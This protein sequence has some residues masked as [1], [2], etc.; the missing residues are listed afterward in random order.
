MFKLE[1]ALKWLAKFQCKHSRIILIATIAFTLFMAIGFLNIKIETDFTKE[2]PQNAVVIKDQSMLSEKF[3]SS[4]SLFILFQINTNATSPINDIRDPKILQ[5]MINLE[6]RLRSRS[7]IRSVQSVASI[8]IYSGIDVPKSKDAAIMV[9]NQIPQ[10]DR[11]FNRDYSQTFMLV[12]SSEESSESNIKSVI[13]KINEDISAAGITS[14]VKVT[15]TGTAP[16]RSDLMDLLIHDTIF[17]TII[18]G[19][20]I[21]ILI[22]ILE[23]FST[24]PTVQI[25]WPIV[26]GVIWTYGFMGWFG[27]PLSII[28]ATVGAMLIGLDV[29]YGTFMVRRVM[30][31]WNN[32]KN[33]EEA[34]IIAVPAIGRAIIGSGGAMIIGFGTLILSTMPMM[35]HLGIVL[36]LGIF[37]RLLMAVFIN[38]AII[39]FAREWEV[40]KSGKK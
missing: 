30:E 34:T 28:T 23:S 36:S 10:A 12:T 7:D 35:Q 18:A 16:L 25:F 5:G 8:F 2:M 15:V 19:I 39:H 3:G 37:F 32:G 33:P 17:T 11:F 1:D 21:L 9:I 6:N 27:V 31:E 22:F 40:N 20:L 4:D 29:E 24:I 26:V 14:D 38:P 13:A